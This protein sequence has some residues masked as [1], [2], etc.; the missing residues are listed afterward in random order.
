MNNL[1]YVIAFF[2]RFAAFLAP[3]TSGRV[4]IAVA[5]IYSSKVM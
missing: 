4:N 2:Q 5:A 3:L 1:S